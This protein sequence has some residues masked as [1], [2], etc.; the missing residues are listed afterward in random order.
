MSI[1]WKVDGRTVSAGNLGRE[2]VKSMRNDLE[3]QIRAAAATMRCPKHGGTADITFHE[4]GGELAFEISGCCDEF[5][6]S[7]YRAVA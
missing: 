2:V 6:E 7:V 5:V 4:R 1:E 3:R